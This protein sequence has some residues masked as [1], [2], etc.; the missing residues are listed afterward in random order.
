ML[1]GRETYSLQVGQLH[2]THAPIDVYNIDP[3]RLFFCGF[4][5]LGIRVCLCGDTADFDGTSMVIFVL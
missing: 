1:T 4:G 2:K 5:E 3:L